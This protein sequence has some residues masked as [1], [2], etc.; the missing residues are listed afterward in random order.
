MHA[1][2]HQLN[3]NLWHSFEGASAKVRLPDANFL[4]YLRARPIP[5]DVPVMSAYPTPSAALPPPVRGGGEA[6]DD[7]FDDFVVAPFAI[8]FAPPRQR[9]PLVPTTWPSSLSSSSVPPHPFAATATPS[10]T[11]SVA[12]LPPSQGSGTGLD[13]CRASLR[14]LSPRQRLKPCDTAAQRQ[15]V[16]TLSLPQS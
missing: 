14:D 6:D 3:C 11:T 4:Q 2:A 1:L 5:E 7:D 10:T 8:W 13:P 16:G 9:F 12:P 15:Q